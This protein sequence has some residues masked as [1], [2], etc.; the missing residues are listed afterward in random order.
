VPS[1][2]NLEHS[3]QSKWVYLH[4]HSGV[5]ALDDLR[6]NA[7]S[8]AFTQEHLLQSTYSWAHTLE[9]MLWTLRTEHFHCSKHSGFSGD[10][11]LDY[12][13][14][15]TVCAPDHLF[16]KKWLCLHTTLDHSLDHKHIHIIKCISCKVLET[17]IHY[18]P[19]DNSIF[20]KSLQHP[21]LHLCRCQCFFPMIRYCHNA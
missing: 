13:I 4:S 11:D 18:R 17:V 16:R 5:S 2:G 20:A 8:V 10:S 9:S 6:W 14:W 1:A 7:F 15:S 21:C 19:P 12:L 3:C